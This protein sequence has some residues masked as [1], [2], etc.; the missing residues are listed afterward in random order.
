M[1]TA[2][3]GDVTIKGQAYPITITPVDT[4]GRVAVEYVDG[5]TQFRASSE[6]T[7]FE[8]S[9]GQGLVKF[10]SFEGS[11]WSRNVRCTNGSRVTMIVGEIETK[12]TGDKPEESGFEV[13]RT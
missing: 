8:D 1:D 3:T 7:V 12:G 13:T 10:R 5:I 2:F 6:A 9:T 4:G 11:G